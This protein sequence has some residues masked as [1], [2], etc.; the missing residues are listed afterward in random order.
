MRE[1]TM[2]EAIREGI[3]EEM[4]RDP[5]LF[6]I[7]EDVGPFGGEHGLSK[8]LWDEFGDWRMRDAPIS[9][10]GILGCALGAA[11]T[12]CRAIAEIPFNDFIC[13]AMDQIVNQAAKMRYMFGGKACIPLL[14]RTT[15]GGYISAA[16]QH[17][18]CLEAWFCHVPG[19][20]VVM[21]SNPIDAKGLVKTCLRIDN[22]IVFFEHKTLYPNK[23]PVPDGEVLI[24][25]GKADVK[26]PGHSAT[27]VA[28]GMLVVKALAAARRLSAEGIEI[29]VIDLRTL[30][31]LDTEMILESVTKT[32]RLV[33]AHEAPERGGF[34]AEVVATVADK[35]YHLLKAPIKRVAAENV[36]IPFSPVLEQHVLPQVEDIV[37]A[38]REVTG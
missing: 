9:E 16:A 22:P 34:G 2:K 24:P 14:I 26:R 29:E 32:G 8:G 1:L 21:P 31:P 5:H 17:S 7:G 25:L 4:R 15:C 33:V 23:G 30:V 19:L 13:I 6:M 27:V 36:P 12:G 37:Q 11:L 35:G 28:T 20:M 18:Q 10:A 3:A 38:V